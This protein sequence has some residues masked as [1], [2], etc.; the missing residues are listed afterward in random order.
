MEYKDYYKTL[1]VE[2]DASEDDIKRAYRKL[3]RKYHPD[4]SKEPDAEEKFKE[5]QEAYEVLH[6]PE[7]RQAYD[8][9]GSGWQAG[10]DFRPPP[11]WE[12]QGFEQ[13]FT[14]TDFGD[15]SD[16]FESLFGHARRAGSGRR[17]FT[18]FRA[19]GQDQHARLRISLE[20]AY[21]GATRTVNLTVPEVDEQGRVQRR[22]RELKVRIPAGVLPGQNIRLQGQGSKGIGG[23][24]AG[25]LF[26]EIEYEPHPYFQVQQRDIYLDLP[27]T[28]WEAVLGGKVAVPTL[29]GK[30]N[31]TIPPNSQTG[32]QMRL[33]GRG[34]PG[35]PAGDQIVRLKVVTPPAKTDEQRSLYEQM[36]DLMPMNPRADL[37]VT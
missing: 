28:P 13:H 19:A 21:H 9:I 31:L 24:E 25:D 16:F 22:Q 33:K 26:L 11:G 5:V 35:K 27:I 2:R 29:G 30:V 23:G 4:V 7:K 12:G 6:D 14:D 1:G 8:N 10:Q 36:R 17:G 37:G 20:D 3:A 32:K 34:L 18:D 15:F